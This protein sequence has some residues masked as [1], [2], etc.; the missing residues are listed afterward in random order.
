MRYVTAS[1]S[2]RLIGAMPVV[3][4]ANAWRQ[5]QRLAARARRAGYKIDK[6][7]ERMIP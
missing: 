2:D 5:R 4:H 7:L 3:R 1:F 6:R